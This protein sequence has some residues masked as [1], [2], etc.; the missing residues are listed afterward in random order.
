VVD[1]AGGDVDDVAASM[2]LGNHAILQ[3]ASV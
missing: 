2:F 3:P 1:K